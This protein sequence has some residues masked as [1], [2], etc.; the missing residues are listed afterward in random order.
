MATLNESLAAAD[1]FGAVKGAYTGAQAARSGLFAEADGGTLFLDELGDTCRLGAADAAAGARNRHLPS[2][3]LEPGRH[4]QRAPDRR[5]RP[6]P[7]RARIQSAAAAAH[8]S[9]C[10][11]RAAAA[12]TARRHRRAA[13]GSAA[14]L[15]P[16]RSRAGGVSPGPGERD[17]QLRLAGQYPPAGQR[18][19]ARGDDPA[20]RRRA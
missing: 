2:A 11:P 6:G 13:A 19:A 7:R 3:R 18:D 12:R 20:R 10:D 17:V 5:H 14:R 1:L 15:H 4:H 8:G 16:G 9:V